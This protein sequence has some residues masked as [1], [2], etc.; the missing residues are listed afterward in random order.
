MARTVARS[1]DA[2]EAR[3]RGKIRPRR[4]LLGGKRLEIRMRLDEGLDLILILLAKQRAG[5]I[6]DAAAGL[7][8][9]DGAG[10]QVALLLETQRNGARSQSPF[11]VG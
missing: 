10:Q 9:T 3:E 5:H 8:I 7:H 11:G 6:G 2:S 1:H 4:D